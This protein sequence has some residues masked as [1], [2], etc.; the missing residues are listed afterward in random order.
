MLDTRL[1]ELYRSVLRYLPIGNAMVQ[2]TVQSVL[3]LIV[4]GFM[5]FSLNDVK[6]WVSIWLSALIAICLVVIATSVSLG[7]IVAVFKGIEVV[8]TWIFGVF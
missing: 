1:N 6:E 5:K 8:G 3:G 7:V 2:G 4:G